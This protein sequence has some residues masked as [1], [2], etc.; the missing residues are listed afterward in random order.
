MTTKPKS[1][2]SPSKTIADLQ[3]VVK[4]R[5][6]AIEKLEQCGSEL[7]AFLERLCEELELAHEGLAIVPEG[8]CFAVTLVRGFPSR[9]EAYQW[10]RKLVEGLDP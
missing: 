7:Q 8:Q 6:A 5:D 4:A 9:I 10:A 2:P 1:Q 3:E